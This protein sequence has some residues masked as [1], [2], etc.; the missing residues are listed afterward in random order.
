MLLEYLKTIGFWAGL[1]L[2]ENKDGG[3]CKYGNKP[4]DFI[5]SGVS[6]D[7]LLHKQCAPWS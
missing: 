6:F 3:I 2:T 5:R 1:D 7:H 4:L